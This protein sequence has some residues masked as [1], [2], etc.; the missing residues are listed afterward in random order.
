MSEKVKALSLLFSVIEETV[1]GAGSA[2]VP[3]GHLFAAI[4]M[5]IP[6]YNL[7]S[8]HAVVGALVEGNRIQKHG[9]VLFSWGVFP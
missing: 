2:G 1:S 9:D 5:K 4:S 3:S 8:H 6:Q 7:A